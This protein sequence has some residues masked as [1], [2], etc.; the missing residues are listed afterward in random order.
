MS[1]SSR[2]PYEIKDRTILTFVEH[3]LIGSTVEREDMIRNPYTP[4]DVLDG[5]NI[6]DVRESR[7]KQR[8]IVSVQCEDFGLEVGKMPV[9][10]LNILDLESGKVSSEIRLAGITDFYSGKINRDPGELAKHPLTEEGKR[11]YK[12]EGEVGRREKIG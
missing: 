8:E 1:D 9:I 6:K 4:E 5:K 12:V 3:M 11:K 2:D 10:A 7:L